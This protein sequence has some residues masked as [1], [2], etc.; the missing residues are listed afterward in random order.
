M[1]ADKSRR[2]RRREYTAQFYRGNRAAFC[3][4]LAE[5]L[6]TSALNLVISWD[7]QQMYDTLSNVPGA[8]PFAVLLL[9]TAGIVALIVVLKWVR[10]YTK[11]RFMERAMR[12][13][14][15]YAF[16][17]LTNK[18]IASFQSEPTAN[19]LS[20]FSNDANSIESGYLETQFDLL[21]NLVLLTGALTMMLAYSPVMTA[22]VCAFFILPISASLLTGK[23][24]EKAER[25]VS[26]RNSAFTAALKDSL[27]GFS[28]MK[29]FRAEGALRRLFGESCQS[30]EQAKC[31]KRKVQ[32]LIDLFSGFAGITAQL[33][34]FLTGIWFVRRGLPITPGMLIVFLDLSGLV[35]MPIRELP[36]M[37][38]A[39][40]ASAALIDKLA[41]ALERNVR[42][43]GL[44]IPARLTQGI[45]LK[46]VSFGYGEGR[47]VLRDISTIFEPGKAY[48][49]VGASG[50]GKSTLLHLLMASHN[51]YSGAVCYDGHELCDIA[52]DSLYEMVSM[53]QQNVFV[54]NASI[55]DNITMFCDF[56]KADIDDAIRRSGLDGVLETRGENCLCGENGANLSGGERQRI[57]IARSLL[58]R[59][60]VLLADEATAALD[61]QTACQIFSAILDLEGITR[62]VVTHTL[63][64][65]MLKR[66]DAILVMKNGCIAEQGSFA[67]LM[68]RREYFYSLYTV[69][70]A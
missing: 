42:D 47:L 12:Q 44:R 15:D 69:A 26:E 48:A 2:M 36:Q 34:T 23:R 10:Y 27:S 38:A 13:Y 43:E 17:K 56:P 65:S 24:V 53:I 4:A 35:I 22:A 5:A 25:T 33:G 49:V 63:E 20:A 37:I 62:I 52:S 6:F 19:Y 9:I 28:V 14:K 7:L 54:F 66:F 45:A 39:R 1:T 46:G 70:Q 55:R 61:A 30:V 40:R 3:I 64:E 31:E 16:G 59:A 50:S 58:R 32:T 67:E 68:Q 11:P 60:S 57:S 51:T 8:R 21:Q 29:S 41:D 18:S